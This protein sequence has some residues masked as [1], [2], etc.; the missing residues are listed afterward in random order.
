MV[1]LMLQEARQALAV[2]PHACESVNDSLPTRRGDLV[3]L[4]SLSYKLRVRVDRVDGFNYLGTI[5]ECRRDGY[6][7]EEIEFDERHIQSRQ[8]L[9]EPELEAA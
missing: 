9:A 1:V 2:G 8:R 7:G 6:V 5:V 4:Q 3:V